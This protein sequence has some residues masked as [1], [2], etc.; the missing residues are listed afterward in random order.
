MKDY[1]KDIDYRYYINNRNLKRMDLDAW[2]SCYIFQDIQLVLEGQ[3]RTISQRLITSS[4]QQKKQQ[5][6]KQQQFAKIERRMTILSLH[7]VMPWHMV[8]AYNFMNNTHNKLIHSKILS[9]YPFLVEEKR[10]KDLKI[11]LRKNV[12]NKSKKRGIG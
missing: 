2:N 7:H 9:T 1:S 5:S 8:T 3:F 6:S 12:W 10:K 4:K 11:K